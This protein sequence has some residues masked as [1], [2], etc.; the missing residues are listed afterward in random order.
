MAFEDCHDIDG[1]HGRIALNSDGEDL[2]QSLSLEGEIG[3]DGDADPAENFDSGDELGQP[4]DKA[5]IVASIHANRLNAEKGSKTMKTAGMG[6]VSL[7]P[8]QCLVAPVWAMK[9]IVLPAKIVELVEPLTIQI[10]Q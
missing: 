7:F 2:E 8:R 4:L 6:A 9:T 3:H 10:V 1:I 5:T